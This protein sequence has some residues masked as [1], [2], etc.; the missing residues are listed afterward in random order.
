[1]NLFDDSE[2]FTNVM[3]MPQAEFIAFQNARKGSISAPLIQSL[4]FSCTEH[5]LLYP[6]C[7]MYISFPGYSMDES[8]HKA[9]RIDERMEYAELVSIT[10]SLMANV[11]FKQK[12]DMALENGKQL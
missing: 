1:M 11:L 8:E 4:K 7:R 3:S 2:I 6:S 12:D 10:T 5:V 9:S